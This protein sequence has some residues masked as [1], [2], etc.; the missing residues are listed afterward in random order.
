MCA[1]LLLYKRGAFGRKNAKGVYNK[2]K[3]TYRAYWHHDAVDSYATLAHGPWSLYAN[4]ADAYFE[5]V[6]VEIEQPSSSHAYFV[7][8]VVEYVNHL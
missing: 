3:P 7:R 2:W 8:D 4:Q 5:F 1:T 6:A